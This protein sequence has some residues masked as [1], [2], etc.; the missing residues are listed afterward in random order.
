[1]ALK[2]VL[3]NFVAPEPAVAHMDDL[4][5][6]VNHA[7][8]NLQTRH[9][10]QIVGLEAHHG[11]VVL[12]MDLPDDTPSF[13]VGRHLR[14]IGGYLLNECAGYQDLVVGKRL[15]TYTEVPV[16][17]SD[18][19]GPGHNVSD[20]DRFAAVQAF[21]ALLSRSDGSARERVQRIYEILR[22]EV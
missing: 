16:L 2:R 13:S 5:A 10:V 22:E 9:H 20:M 6:A 11:D 3:I 19:A 12:T 4:R 14:G 15:L 17:T 21:V 7:A 1:M 18:P 8:Y